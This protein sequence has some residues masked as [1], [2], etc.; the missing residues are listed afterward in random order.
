MSGRLVSRCSPNV[1]EKRTLTVRNQNSLS[2][3]VPSAFHGVGPSSV[4][5]R[6]MLAIDDEPRRSASIALT[7]AMK[8]NGSNW[9]STSKPRKP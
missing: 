7:S 5:L 6:L 2:F 3:A 1:L 8:W 4:S 9:N